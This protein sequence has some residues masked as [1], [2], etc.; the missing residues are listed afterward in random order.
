[1]P[2]KLERSKSADGEEVVGCQPQSEPQNSVRLRVVRGIAGLPRSLLIREAE[3][4]E[5]VD[6]ARLRTQR[7]LQLLDQGGRVRGESRREPVTLRGGDRRHGGAR[8]CPA[9]HASEE[10]GDGGEGRRR[11]SDQQPPSAHGFCWP[12]VLSN[13]LNGSASYG[14]DDWNGTAVASTPS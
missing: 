14:N 10:E 12:F 2:R 11:R 1:M 9:K 13:P 5:P 4:V 8:A 3:Q 6:V 7:S